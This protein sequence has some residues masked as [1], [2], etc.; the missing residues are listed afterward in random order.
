ME[1]D[2]IYLGN[3]Y[4][5]Y[6]IWDKVRIKKGEKQMFLVVI[7]WPMKQNLKYHFCAF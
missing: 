7:T 1:E 3:Q 4:T 5:C 6:E 2:Y